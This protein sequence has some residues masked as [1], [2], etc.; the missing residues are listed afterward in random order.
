MMGPLRYIF[1]FLIGGTDLI[2]PMKQPPQVRFRFYL[3]SF[4]FNKS[5]FFYVLLNAYLFSPV[6]SY[7]YLASR[8]AY[9]RVPSP[10]FLSAAEF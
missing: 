3:F 5:L 10:V 6:E 2:R 8:T 1:N 7:G 4:V 9:W